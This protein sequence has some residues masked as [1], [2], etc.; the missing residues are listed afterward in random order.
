MDLTASVLAAT[1]T[2]MPADPALEGI[3]LLPIL[4][5]TSPVVERTLFWRMFYVDRRQRAVRSGDWKL[6]LDGE[7]AMVFNVRSDTGEQNDLA[8]ERQDVARRLRL[9]MAAWERDVDGE[10]RARA[11][12]SIR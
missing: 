9:L 7:A 6:V 10:A 4:A 8:N 1:N 12:R 11:G 2:P 3:N 5:E